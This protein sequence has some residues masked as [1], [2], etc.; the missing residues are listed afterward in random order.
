M[1]HDI[2][3]PNHWAHWLLILDVPLLHDVV[4]S[5][6][7]DLPI[8]LRLRGGQDVL[9]PSPDGSLYLFEWFQVGHRSRRVDDSESTALPLA[10]SS[11]RCR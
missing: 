5:N 1:L 9:A 10:S 6:G 7:V 4:D 11:P 2:E 3:H 8:E